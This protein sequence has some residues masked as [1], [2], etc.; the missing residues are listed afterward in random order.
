MIY[1]DNG[2]KLMKY[3][4]KYTIDGREHTQYI[5]DI[6][7]LIGH[8]KNGVIENLTYDYADY[9]E[10]M[11]KRMLEVASMPQREY[12]SVENY[13]LNGLIKEGSLLDLM[14]R[15]TEL[16]N[17]IQEMTIAMG[18]KLEDVEKTTKEVQ[19]SSITTMMALLQISALIE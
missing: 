6:D 16:E 3:V 14:R 4:A 19:D 5:E 8:E 15:N 12:D 7:Y 13:V 10:D 1:Y 11:K 18:K 17:T 9:D 2:F